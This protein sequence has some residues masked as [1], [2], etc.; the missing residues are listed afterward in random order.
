MIGVG[1]SP[2]YVFCTPLS[3]LTIRDST[4]PGCGTWVNHLPARFRLG[5][6]RLSALWGGTLN[7]HPAW[8]RPERPGLDNST[9]QIFTRSHIG[10]ITYYD[11]ADHQG[12]QHPIRAG[13]VHTMRS[14]TSNSIHKPIRLVPLP[15]HDERLHTPT[16]SKLCLANGPRRPS[17][18][19]CQVSDRHTHKDR[20]KCHSDQETGSIHTPSS[21]S[22]RGHRL[23]SRRRHHRH[24]ET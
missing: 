2:C 24:G 13:A 19:L 23:W 8:L 4:N 21:P 6:G 7:K 16:L 10:C 1:G 20:P 11:C 14:P 17:H 15:H 3:R 12:T 9:P 22:G 18:R 5:F